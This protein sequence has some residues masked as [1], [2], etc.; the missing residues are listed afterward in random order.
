MMEYGCINHLKK[1]SMRGSVM[2]M[3]LPSGGHSDG[4]VREVPLQS[5][6]IVM[7]DPEQLLNKLIHFNV[8]SYA[9]KHD[10][11]GGLRNQVLG[12]PNKGYIQSMDYGSN[13][14][15]SKFGMLVEP[16]ATCDMY[17]SSYSLIQTK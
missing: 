8:D 10:A 15:Q 12:L 1:D 4:P 6:N 2:S 11:L 7:G 5:M 3:F 13:P 16:S 17:E 14:S 9:M